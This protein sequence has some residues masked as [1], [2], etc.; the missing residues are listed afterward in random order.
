M[1]TGLFYSKECDDLISPI[2]LCVGADLAL[3]SEVSRQ[4]LP[5]PEFQAR[6]HV[7]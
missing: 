5:L 2:C 6:F 7:R 3:F 1:M 4:P